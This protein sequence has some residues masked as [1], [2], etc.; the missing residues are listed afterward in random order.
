MIKDKKQ[1]EVTIFQLKEDKHKY[2]NRQ[3]NKETELNTIKDKL[4]QAEALLIPLQEEL[5]RV[6]LDLHKSDTSLQKRQTELNSFIKENNMLKNQIMD[7]E[8]KYGDLNQIDERIRVASL[9]EAKI[10]DL[11]KKLD[12]CMQS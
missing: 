12:N 10:G 8:K 3:G 9:K 7:I 4:E 6:K 1:L 2:W 5:E 11:L